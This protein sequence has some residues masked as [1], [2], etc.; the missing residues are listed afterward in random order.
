MKRTLTICTVGIS[1]V[2][3]FHRLGVS[4]PERRERD[5]RTRIA[6]L[7]AETNAAR[8]A[9]ED[10]R[11]LELECTRIRARLAGRDRISPGS[12]ALVWFPEKMREHFHRF[13]IE[14]VSARVNTTISEP[15]LRGFERIFWTITLPVLPDAADLKRALLAVC[16]LETT[17]SQLCIVGV[18]VS[19]DAQSIGGRS[20][21]ITA[22]L[23]ARQL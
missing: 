23:L 2:V 3:L 1:A 15:A 22:S 10:V 17:E 5:L 11:A 20:A 6:G 21:V 7:A 8:H 13:G 16:E 9:I 4:A 14:K 19:G 18:G 12:P